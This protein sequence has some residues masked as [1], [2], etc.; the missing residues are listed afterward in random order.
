HEAYVRSPLLHGTAIEERALD[1]LRGATR[2]ESHQAL[3]DAQRILDQAQEKPAAEWRLR[4]Y[5]LAEALFQ[6]IR[7]QL[8]V[9][10]YRAIAVGRG[11]TLDSLET[12]LNNSGWLAARFAEAAALDTDA[13]RLAAIDRIVRWTDP[14]PGGY[15]DDLGR[16]SQQ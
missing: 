12:P 14:R 4:V 13:A 7:Q 10:R 6:S 9:E 8:S 15:Y 2:G 16:P 11:A 3:A 5:A 1:R